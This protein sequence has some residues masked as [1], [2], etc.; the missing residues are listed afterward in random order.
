[1]FLKNL[2]LEREFVLK[3]TTTVD[4]AINA[5]MVGEVSVH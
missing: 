1:M 4:N 5:L 2:P 3:T